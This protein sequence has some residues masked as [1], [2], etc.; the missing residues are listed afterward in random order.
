MMKVNGMLG[1]H[2][3][4]ESKNKISGAI[5]LRIKEGKIKVF[6]INDSRLVG[7]S[8]PSK[9]PEV[10]IKISER[11]RGRKRPWQSERMRMNNPMKNPE[12]VKKVSEK[13]K[14]RPPNSG[15]F[16]IGNHPKTEFKKSQHASPK[17]EFQKG[18]HVRTEFTAE[19]LKQLWQTPEYRKLQISKKVGEKSHLWRGGISF[20]HYTHEFNSQLKE[21]IRLRDS[22]TCQLCKLPE[23]DRKH[24]IHHIDYN[25]KNSDPKNMITL[26]I[27]CHIRTNINRNFW[28]LYFTN[29][30]ETIYD[31]I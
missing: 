3:T 29:L 4:E 27:N 22:F 16:K 31:K 14:G 18:N 10:R 19:R 15:S 28:L 12:V 1:K 7:E 21:A 6:K 25:K 20:E 13:L 11:L 30:M 23:N 9:R 17:T 24:C 8:N 2:H 26:C 5:K